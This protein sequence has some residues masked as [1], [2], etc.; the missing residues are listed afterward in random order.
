M[1]GETPVQR[2]AQISQL[3]CFFINSN[4]AALLGNVPKKEEANS[5][6]QR[7]L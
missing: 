4:F 3:P 5:R 1:F 2:V 7:E 6:D